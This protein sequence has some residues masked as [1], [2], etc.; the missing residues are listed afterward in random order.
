M[1]LPGVYLD[2]DVQSAAV[3]EALRS[4]DMVVLT[5][6]EAEM[7]AS[8]DEEQLLFAI[9][10]GMVLATCNVSD[11][12]RIHTEWLSSGREHLGIIIIAQQK[13]GPGE[14]AQRIIRLL[15]SVSGG[16]MRGRLEFVSQW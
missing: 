5:T 16:D 8:T 14:L 2:E 13:W 3:I 15:S 9:A 4:R 10:R 6:T 7:T 1:S 11:F 12:Y